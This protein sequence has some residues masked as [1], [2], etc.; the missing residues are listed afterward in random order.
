MSDPLFPLICL[1]S[2]VEVML[3]NL[4]CV[5]MGSSNTLQTAQSLMLDALNC[6]ATARVAQAVVTHNLIYILYHEHV[7]T[8]SFKHS[9]IH[10][11]I[12]HNVCRSCMH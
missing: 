2:A 9:E 11:H 10:S 3:H 8:H 12:I 5:H 4:V 1:G 6:M 7:C